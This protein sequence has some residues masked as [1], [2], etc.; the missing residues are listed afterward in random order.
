MCMCT[1]MCM[2]T[3]TISIMEDA[4]KLL[5]NKKH[6][7]ESFSEVI[8]RIVRKERDIMQF[9]GAWKHISDAEAESMKK[10]IYNLNKHST[11][12]LLHR[13]KKYDLP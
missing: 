12:E 5:L 9:A 11:K 1:R 8:R 2:V 13:L 10:H 6:K 4:Y 3:K 7:N